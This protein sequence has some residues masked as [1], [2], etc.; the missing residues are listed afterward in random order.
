M[1]RTVNALQRSRSSSPPSPPPPPPP[2]LASASSPTSMMR[3]CRRADS[4]SSQSSCEQMVDTSSSSSIERGVVID[5]DCACINRNAA[6]TGSGMG[7][8][9]ERVLRPSSSSAVVVAPG[10]RAWDCASRCEGVSASRARAKQ[11][12]NSSVHACDACV[13]RDRNGQLTRAMRV[14]NNQ[15]MS[16][17]QRT[18][19]YASGCVWAS[20]NSARASNDVEPN[21]T[22]MRLERV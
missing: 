10:V 1:C 13:A 7:A 19:S 3:R 20:T 9:C 6:R 21:R 15:I 16:M 17:T 2:P 18:A 12:R 11:T 4:H 14:L 22:S 8:V 5:V